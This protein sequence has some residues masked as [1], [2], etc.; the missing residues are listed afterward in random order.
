MRRHSKEKAGSCKFWTTASVVYEGGRRVNEVA[1]HQ[2]LLNHCWFWKTQS[3]RW[4][5]TQDIGNSGLSPLAH[6]LTSALTY[7]TSQ[8]QRSPTD[9]S[10]VDLQYKHV[11]LSLDHTMAACTRVSLEPVL[12]CFCSLRV[13]FV[14]RVLSWQEWMVSV[15]PCHLSHYG[16][17]K[18]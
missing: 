15:R 2:H 8:C 10:A 18:E 14:S 6:M 13:L 16:I 1:T 3:P 17:Q 11:V 9:S 4:V 12:A 5:C 7:E